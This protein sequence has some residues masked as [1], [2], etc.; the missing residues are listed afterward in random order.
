MNVGGVF[1]IFE[2]QVWHVTKQSG[3]KSQGI[4]DCI[5]Y[6][7]IVITTASYSTEPKT[8]YLGILLLIFECQV[9]HVSKPSIVIS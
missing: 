2:C 8:K 9:Q 3:V 5:L 4:C 6:L 1:P 7:N